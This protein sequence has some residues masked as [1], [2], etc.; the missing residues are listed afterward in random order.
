MARSRDPF[1]IILENLVDPG[2]KVYFQ[3]PA[4]MNMT[5][6]CIRYTLERLDGV[7]AD[8]ETYLTQKA[9]N[10]VYISR[11]P[12]SVVPE[13]LRM[14]PMCRFIRYYAVDNLHHWVFTIYY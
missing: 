5:F 13:K 8:S 2:G 9:Y 7:N 6:P 11:D 3:P 10:V 4:T 12:D 14:L 1:Q